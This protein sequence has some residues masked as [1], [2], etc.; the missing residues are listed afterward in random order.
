L[1]FSPIGTNSRSRETIDLAKMKKELEDQKA[2][3]EKH[4]TALEQQ[5]KINLELMTD[6]AKL[7]EELMQQLRDEMEKEK[8]VNVELRKADAAKRQRDIAEI[9]RNFINS[10][11]ENHMADWVNITKDFIVSEIEN[12]MADWVNITKDFIVSEV[13]YYMADWVNITKEFIVSEVEKYMANS[14]YSICDMGRV[15]F[16][17]E[18]TPSGERKI[19]TQRFKINFSKVFPTTPK[20]A[21]SLY[22]TNAQGPE[23]KWLRTFMHFVTEESAT[24]L[25]QTYSGELMGGTWIACV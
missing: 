21:A 18:K 17:S 2:S 15:V 23:R 7:R 1:F 19:I 14:G 22:L 4:E 8:I 9:T 6:N 16:N 20:A 12:Y 25:V 13:E 10:E 11:I 3:L 24:I 5:S